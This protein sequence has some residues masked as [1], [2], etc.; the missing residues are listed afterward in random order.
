MTPKQGIISTDRGIMAPRLG[1]FFRETARW[2][3][4]PVFMH[5]SMVHRTTTLARSVVRPLQYRCE[6]VLRLVSLGPPSS[7]HTPAIS[8]VSRRAIGGLQVRQ[9]KTSETLW[10]TR[11]FRMRQREHGAPKRSN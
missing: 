3:M 2:P 4:V 6:N 9:S 7:P 5:T 10:K 11:A 8:K 1:G